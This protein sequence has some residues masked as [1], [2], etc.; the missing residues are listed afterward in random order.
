MRG[1]LGGHALLG[2]V[3]AWYVQL[4]LSLSCFHYYEYYEPFGNEISN[5]NEKLMTRM[6]E[7]KD[8][9]D[10]TFYGH[11]WIALAK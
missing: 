2:Q 4:K 1:N 5:Y 9:M 11:H 10:L 6:L 7:I 3:T 8:V